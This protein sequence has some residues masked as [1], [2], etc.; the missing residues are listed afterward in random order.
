MGFLAG[1]RRDLPSD[2]RSQESSGCREAASVRYALAQMT[3][4]E[5][6]RLTDYADCAG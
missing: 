6:K 1:Q 5:K 3:Q 4:E 2:P